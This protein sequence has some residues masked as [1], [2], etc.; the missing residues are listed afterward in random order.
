MK[1]KAQDSLVYLNNELIIKYC[2]I[3][4]VDSSIIIILLRH[5]IHFSKDY[6]QEAETGRKYM[7]PKTY[8]KCI[9]N[10]FRKTSMAGVNWEAEPA[11]YYEN[12]CQ[13][14]GGRGGGGGTAVRLPRIRANGNSV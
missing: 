10:L 11:G 6:V 5:G 7:E 8:S 3:S 4:C 9:N 2:I 12:G 13:R 14:C 1:S